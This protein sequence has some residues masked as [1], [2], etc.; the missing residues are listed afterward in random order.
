MFMT[1]VL[2]SLHG[3][4]APVRFVDGR[5]DRV[6]SIYTAMSQTSIGDASVS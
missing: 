1:G 5:S 6:Q 4:M 2:M 3:E